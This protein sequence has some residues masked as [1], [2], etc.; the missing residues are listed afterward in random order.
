MEMSAQRMTDY[1][2]PGEKNLCKPRKD[3]SYPSPFLKEYC[4][5][6]STS[7][8]YPVAFLLHTK[9]PTH[10][11]ANAGCTTVLLLL[12]LVVLFIY[13]AE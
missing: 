9:H 1:F 6:E 5:D 11:N 8:F 2:F 3:G 12:F 13:F 7:S 10:R 4:N